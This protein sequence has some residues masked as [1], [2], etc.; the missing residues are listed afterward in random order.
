[1]ARL[2]YLQRSN[3]EY[4]DELFAR[5]QLDPGSVDESWRYFFDGL[6]VGSAQQ[7]HISNGIQIGSPMAD[8]PTGE[9]RT[10]ERR[11]ITDAYADEARVAELITAYREYG[12]LLAHIDPLGDAPGANP[13]LELTKYRLVDRDLDRVFQAGQLLG[14][15]PATLRQILTR[16]KETYCGTIGVEFTHIQDA[17]IREWVQKKMETSR[18]HEE[19]TPESRRFILKRLVESETFERFLHTRYVAQKRFS[20]EGGE[21]LI[22]CLDRIIESGAELGVEQIVMGMAHRGRLNVLHNIYRKNAEFILTEFEQAYSSDPAQGEGDVKY[23]MGFSADLKTRQGKSVHLSLASNPSHLEFVN[24][25][26]CGIA[27]GKQQYL[28]DEDRVKVVPILIHGDAAFAG[29][30]IV[31]ETLNLSQL[32]GFTVGGT[33]HIIVNN[34]VGFTTDP[35]DSRSTTY[36]TD[37][38]KMLE[39]PIFHVNGDDP[40]AVWYVSRLSTEFRQHFKKDVFIDLVCYRKYGHNESDEPTF[41]QPVLYKKIKNHPSPREVYAARLAQAKIVSPEEVQ[42]Q[43]DGVITTLTEAQKK[44]REEKPKPLVQSFQSV[45]KNFHKPSNGEYFELIETGVDAARLLELSLELN[46]IPQGFEIHPKLSR[47]LE[48]K[49]EAVTKGVGIDWGNAETLAY[50]TL[51]AEGYAVRLSGQDVERGTF[52]HRHCVLCDYSTGMKHVP[53]N[54]LQKN[55]D[56]KQGDF[57]VFNSSLSEAG[58]LG[59]EYGW[60]LADPNSL[61]IWEAQFGDFANSAQVI[62][63]QFI[64]SGESKWQ[65]ASGLILFLPHG[66]EGQGPEH[67]SARL[68]RFLQLAGNQNF[69]VCN[70]STP[71]QVFHLIRRQLKRQFRKPL[72]LMTPKSLLRHPQAISTLKELSHGS[73]QE[74]LDDAGFSDAKR[75]AAAKRVVL[76]SGKLFYEIC[77]E[78]ESQGLESQVAIIRLEQLY[79][80]HTDLLAGILSRYSSVKEFTW[81]QEEPLNMGA[82]TYLFHAWHGVDMAFT[83]RVG[84]RPLIYAGRGV[85]AAP[86]VGSAK[87][88]V[89]DQKELIDRALSGV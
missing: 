78:R 53:L 43:I 42:S 57:F 2:N 11:R 48:A 86:A 62:I 21:S 64:S 59:F 18:N 84:G 65:R 69:S 13:L 24:P 87:Q 80:L 55:R 63:D 77:T 44:T 41:T 22:T 9:R 75:A 19:L 71:A 6:E 38:A 56:D 60:S 23:H 39:V 28:G 79:P 20:I 15:G 27:R 50:A 25:V 35:S 30:G 76:C 66:Y 1:M 7:K 73:F 51:L 16:L 14:L 47:F 12:R 17:Q 52:T 81:I 72:V 49:H 8:S 88:H 61:V 37:L 89:K 74:V 4:I 36:A 3:A 58:V 68:E 33:I 67:S 32:K 26:I 45:W 5:Y 82:W 54:H 34:Q 83:Q 10:G 29:Q 46:T 40:E 70:L 85:A 31:Y